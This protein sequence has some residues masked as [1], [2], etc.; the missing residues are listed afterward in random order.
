[1]WLKK[2]HASCTGSFLLF[3]FQPP[4]RQISV[5]VGRRH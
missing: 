3:R 2:A 1:L 4:Q 5:W